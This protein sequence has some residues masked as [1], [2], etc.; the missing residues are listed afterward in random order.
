MSGVAA[1]SDDLA[2]WPRCFDSA[3]EFVAYLLS[4]CA[5]TDDAVSAV[6]EFGVNALR[7]THFAL[8]GGRFTVKVRRWP[9]GISIGVTDQGGTSEP[10]AREPDP[11]E[12]SGRGLKTVATLASRWDWTGDVNGR[13]VIAVFD[14]AN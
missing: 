3:R 5:L 7:H 11:M 13:T 4:G 14:M 12:E 6:G 2:L 10:A 8:P 1:A 9:S